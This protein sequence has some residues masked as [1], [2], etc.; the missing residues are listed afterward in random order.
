MSDG[1]WAEPM[2]ILSP[3]K[4][5][6]PSSDANLPGGDVCRMR[7]YVDCLLMALASDLIAFSLSV[8]KA[9]LRLPSRT[10][11]CLTKEASQPSPTPLLAAKSANIVRE[12]LSPAVR[13]VI[14]SRSPCRSLVTSPSSVKK[15]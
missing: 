9:T 5:P 6:K 11:H 7:S 1:T 10:I 13:I 8:C 12:P 4:S 14:K 15:D 2:L 3:N